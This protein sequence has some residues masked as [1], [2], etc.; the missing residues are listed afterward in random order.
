MPMTH[1]GYYEICV[2]GCLGE[3]WTHWFDGVQ[4]AAAP[5]R[6]G[7]TLLRLP[8]QDASL[9]HGVLA[10]IGSLNLTLISVRLIDQP[11]EGWE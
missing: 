1:S 5:G 2:Q 6:P 3:V 8:A 9:L 10:Q 11:C 4:L 7:V